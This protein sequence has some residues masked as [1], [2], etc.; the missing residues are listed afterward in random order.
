MLDDTYIV[1][2]DQLQIGMHRGFALY[3]SAPFSFQRTEFLD[4]GV[5]YINIFFALNTYTL[6]QWVLNADLLVRIGKA[7]DDFEEIGIPDWLFSLVGD[8][9][10]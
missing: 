9:E 4:F 1:W 6:G 8:S 3:L 10:Q 7:S 5:K 2:L